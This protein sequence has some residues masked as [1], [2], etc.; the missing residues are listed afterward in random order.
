MII[1]NAGCKLMVMF[2]MRMVM[3]VIRKDRGLEWSSVGHQQDTTA[4]G[5]MSSA[6]MLP[7]SRQ[8]TQVLSLN[9]ST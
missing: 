1:T 3:F 5:H 8:D 2:V 9:S 6:K 7:F 4:E